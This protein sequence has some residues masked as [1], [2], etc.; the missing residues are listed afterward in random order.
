MINR[1]SVDTTTNKYYYGT[2]E[3][4]FKED[5]SNYTCSCRNKSREKNTQFSKY[6]WEL[7]EKYTN[8]FINWDDAMKSQKFVC[9]LQKHDLCNCGELLLVRADSDVFCCINVM[10]LFQNSG[11]EIN[12]LWSVLR[13]DKIL[14]IT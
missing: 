5:F 3:N 8:C 4:G 2:W 10:S 9:G 11:I 13:T 6:V 14:S 1:A 12:L 7:K